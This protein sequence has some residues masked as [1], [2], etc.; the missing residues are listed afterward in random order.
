MMIMLIV[1]KFFLSFMAHLSI[2]VSSHSLWARFSL[3][4]LGMAPSPSLQPR[5]APATAALASE[6]PP[7]HKTP[8]MKLFL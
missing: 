8:G 4:D 7:C 6:S 3:H 1:Y 2:R 5:R